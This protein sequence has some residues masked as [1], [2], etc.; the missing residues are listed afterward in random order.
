MAEQTFDTLKVSLN[1][2]SSLYKTM[3]EH[4]E[5]FCASAERI[6]GDSRT[7]V[8][9]ISAGTEGGALWLKFLDRHI[10][11]SML[12]DRKNQKGVLRVDDLLAEGPHQQ[13]VRI[14]YNGTGE[15]D[16]SGGYTG[17]NITLA[18]EAD[19]PTLVFFIINT[20]LDHDPCG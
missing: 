5:R 4:F 13:I 6:A 17:K 14:P 18:L 8:R 7:P 2:A 3:R 16:L 12:L 20:A 10:R 19:H 11:V 1:R 15:T 9:G